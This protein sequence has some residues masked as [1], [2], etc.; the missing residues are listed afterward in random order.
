M[1]DSITCPV[2]L[3][4]PN[5]SFDKGYER[6]PTLLLTH[7]TGQPLHERSTKYTAIASKHI[8]AQTYFCA[9]VMRSWSDNIGKTFNLA[10]IVHQNHVETLL[11]HAKTTNIHLVVCAHCYLHAESDSEIRC[12]VCC[13]GLCA[14][15][16]SLAEFAASTLLQHC[17]VK[18]K[19][20]F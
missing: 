10:A 19:L 17:N 1:S 13:R 6:I 3:V 14:L 9:L 5:V 12:A 16:V 15:G 7:S 2:R 11:H 4:L 20:L 18:A 8:Y